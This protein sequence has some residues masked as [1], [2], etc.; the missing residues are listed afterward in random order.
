M[1]TVVNTAAEQTHSSNEFA[2]PNKLMG[3]VSPEKQFYHLLE[4]SDQWICRDID[5]NA[6]LELEQARLGRGMIEGSIEFCALMSLYSHAY[7]KFFLPHFNRMSEYSKRQLNS[8]DGNLVR[9]EIIYT[10]D[11]VGDRS[12]TTIIICGERCPKHYYKAYDIQC[13]HELVNDEC[14][15]L[16][17][18]G[19]RWCFQPQIVI[20]LMIKK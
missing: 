11:K 15:I 13:V 18:W 16:E 9:Y 10:G 3:L 4:R 19:T 1:V 7:N 20:I 14:F 2:L 8:D 12:R 6:S 5:D 17:K